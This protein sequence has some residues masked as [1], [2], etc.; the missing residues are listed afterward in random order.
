MI[1]NIQVP[2]IRSSRISTIKKPDGVLLLIVTPQ[3]LYKHFALVQDTDLF[4]DTESVTLCLKTSL[5]CILNPYKAHYYARKLSNTVVAFFKKIKFK[6]KGFRLTSYRKR[7]TLEF[8]FGHSHLYLLFM[9]QLHYKRFNKYR[10][11]FYTKNKVVL[12]ETIRRV[13]AVR[14]INVYTLRGLRATKMLVIKRKG[15][16]SPTL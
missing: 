15:R 8:I 3:Y 2:I 14:P 5:P 16:K 4:V 12:D 10:Y 6:G 9:Q 1:I 11:I 7:T 13:V